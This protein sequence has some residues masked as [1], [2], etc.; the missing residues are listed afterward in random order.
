MGGS[1]KKQT[2][3]YKYSIGAHM[4]LI[5]GIADRLTRIVVGD[6]TAWAGGNTGGR[7]NINKPSLFG[8]EQREGGI[9]GAVD[10]ETGTATQGPN[11]YLQSKLGAAIPAFRG[12]TAA[13]LRHCYVGLNPYLKN[14]AFRV[15]RIHRR[16]DGSTQ[17]YDAR[18][19]IGSWETWAT[20]QAFYFA[21]DSSNSMNNWVDSYGTTRIASA[22]QAIGIALDRI[23]ELKLAS[24]DVRVDIM[25][26]SW[27]G[28]D[29]DP[30]ARSS[31]TR[32]NCG[33]AEI[34]ELK[35]WVYSLVAPS[36]FGTFFPGAVA[37]AP[38]Y[39][40]AS[41]AEADRTLF[42]VTDGQPQIPGVENSEN[43][44]AARAYATEAGNTVASIARLSAFGF[45]IDLPDTTETNKLDN[46]PADGVPVVD[47]DNP[48]ALADAI[49]FASISRGHQDM[50]P[51][52]IIRECLV[53]R[54][55]GMGYQD[56][57]I[58]DTAFTAAANRLFSEGMGISIL[59]DR[60]SDIGAFVDE[61][62]RHIDGVL[63]VDRTTGKFVLRLIRDD[64]NP[65]TIPTLGPADIER[66]EDYARP[67]WG[68]LV[69]SVTVNFWD[70]NTGKTST[71]TVDDPAAV[72]MQGAVN[73]RKLEY[74]GFTTADIA[75]RV[76]ARDL[77][78]LS[79]PL[80]SCTI[81]ANRKA[82][83]LNI[84]DVFR[85]EWPD[86]HAGAIIMRVTGMALGDG[87]SN[88]VRLTCAEDVFALPEVPFI[89]H[90]PPPPPIVQNAMAVASRVAVEVPYFEAVQRFSQRTV[91]ATLADS[92]LAGYVMAAGGHPG[93]DALQA[94]MYTDAGAGFDAVGAL[95]FAP[96]ARLSAAVTA[97]A[98][99]LP[100]T[101][102]SDVSGWR[103]GSLAYLGAEIVRID[104]V[105]PGTITVGR[106]CLDT[107]PAPHPS[108]TALIAYD[109]YAQLDPAEYA[110]GE[111]VSVK[112]ITIT[113]SD[114]LPID[115]AP[116]DIVTLAQRAYRPYP[117]GK[118][119]IN[120]NAYPATI[121]ATADL[122]LT[123]A[124]RDR[125]QQTGGAV[126]DTSAAS[127]GPEAG[128]TYTLRIYGQSGDL[129]KTVSGISGT[130]YTYTAAM[131][132]A[133]MG[134]S[135]AAVWAEIDPATEADFVQ[136]VAGNGSGTLVAVTSSGRASKST[137]GGETWS[138]IGDIALEGLTGIAYGNGVWVAV[139]YGVVVTSPDTV[140]WTSRAYPFGSAYAYS[141]AFGSGVFVMGGESGSIAT[142]PSGETWTNRTSGFGTTTIRA[143]AYGDGKFVAVG[144]GSTVSMSANAGVSWAA[145]S[146]VPGSISLYAVTFGNGL[147]VV[148]GTDGI[149]GKL[150]TT[151]D[152]TAWTIRDAGFGSWRISGLAYGGGMF[153]AV[154]YHTSFQY[155]TPA[156]IS[157][158]YSGLTWALQPPV[159]GLDAANGT[160]ELY[161][162]TYDS[163]FVAVGWGRE[164]SVNQSIGARYSSSGGVALN[165]QLR[166]E[167][168]AVRDGLVSWQMH[169]HAVTRA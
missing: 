44:P 115:A 19:A 6:K 89:T 168:E 125:V 21:L 26:V 70:H 119:L 136:G 155:G 92:P 72:Q 118:L 59:W 146:S 22:K 77:R 1:S 90:E 147:W 61:I 153:V 93:G 74:P 150:A 62:I 134:V 101:A 49:N 30:Y 66:V 148:G 124:H 83:S 71:V 102:D 158:S 88:K 29:G 129:G 109:D 63:Y 163:G 156:K 149:S 20:P 164:N 117:P 105:E 3:G 99:S 33:A 167:L 81:Y 157:A 43:S 141:I 80:L 73:A 79:T 84:G 132:L 76:A 116:A 152:L 130:S 160:Y 144:Y 41:P 133:D 112:L 159:A 10:F 47:G 40:D 135:G 75:A 97:A 123:W 137:D 131:E 12:V 37:D 27:G 52:H 91:D 2:V 42:F 38:A 165:A 68:E 39:F 13:V 154:G 139:G 143:I 161:A 128:T 34:D 87:R 35:N 100:I 121:G 114:E 162:V 111:S 15:Q 64:Y 56:A 55:W 145:Q 96:S 142:S 57:D 65:L 103:I 50:N 8:G 36:D 169:N 166:I 17:W 140:T 86:F 151:P 113:P 94:E 11:D 51:A 24:A 106:G 18:A 95:D 46:T 78:A 53:D 107:V 32:R 127:I 54:H 120:G 85:F 108:G 126:I 25:I 7:V 4:V 138:L 23:L 5:Q 31:I 67:A 9:V 110:A 16:M 82:A 122:A 104:I 60:Q 48:Q 28:R 98:V 14:W 45:N 58:D 69:N